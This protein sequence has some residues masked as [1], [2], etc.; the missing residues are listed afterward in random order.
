M[1]LLIVGEKGSL[2][3]QRLSVAPNQRV[4]QF[5]CH[6]SPLEKRFNHSPVFCPYP[7][8]RKAYIPPI[9]PLLQPLL[10]P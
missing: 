2:M 3:E 1:V 9:F 4:P 7:K 8:G 10:L 6:F 5:G